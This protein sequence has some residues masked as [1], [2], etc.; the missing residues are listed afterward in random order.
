MGDIVIQFGDGKFI[1]TPKSNKDILSIRKDLLKNRTDAE[2]QSMDQCK[3]RLYRE[4][5]SAPYS[6]GC[7]GWFPF[8]DCG[9]SNCVMSRRNYIPIEKFVKYLQKA[10]RLLRDDK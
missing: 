10:S 6:N 4:H 8:Y 9:C 7:S 5:F 2:I 3:M 1:P